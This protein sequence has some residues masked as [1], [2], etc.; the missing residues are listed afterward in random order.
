MS[1]IFSHVP[2]TGSA[3][4]C[5]T[6]ANA[7]LSRRG[8]L[9][10]T[11]AVAASGLAFAPRRSMAQTTLTPAAALQALMDGNRRYVDENLNSLEEDL[12]ILKQHTVEKQEPF[13]AVLSCADS[14]VPV[15]LLFDQSIGHLFVNRVAGNI[16]TPEIIASLEYGAAVLGTALIMVL[17][18][19]GCGAVKAAMYGKTAVI[20]NSAFAPTPGSRPACW[21]LRRRC[22]P[23]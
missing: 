16:V 9:R 6:G 15:E 22:L 14:R 2:H 18:H 5:C 3:C 11:G 7:G 21:P 13:A 10:A 23:A 12:G 20:W 19:G 1:R 4:S 8:L 17:G